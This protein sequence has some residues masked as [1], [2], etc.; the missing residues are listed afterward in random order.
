M[1][2]SSFSPGD[3]L[4]I[5]NGIEITE[6]GQTTSPITIEDVNPR[7][8][9]T[10][11]LGGGAL[12]MKPVT[13]RKRLTVNLLPGSAQS[14]SLVAMEKADVTI[15]GSW[16]QLGQ[17]EAE[18]LVDGKIVSRGPRGRA[19]E[20]TGSVTDDQFVIEFRDSSEV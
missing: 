12:S 13:R 9:M 7:T 1:S 14:R 11:G 15:Q 4:L 17:I 2:I 5:L 16:A 6:F 3:G 8:Q 19:G 10:Y 18:V 20:S